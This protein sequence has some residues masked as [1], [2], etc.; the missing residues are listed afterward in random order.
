M[1]QLTPVIGAAGA[2]DRGQIYQ[3]QGEAAWDA[4]STLEL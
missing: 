1:Y 3:L 2:A 4:I